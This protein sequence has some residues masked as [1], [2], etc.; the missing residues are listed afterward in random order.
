[1]LRTRARVVFLLIILILL[2]VS[3]LLGLVTWWLDQQ[4]PQDRGAGSELWTAGG[5]TA[6]ASSIIT[7]MERWTG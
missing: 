6:S 7:G 1:M 2:V 3:G 4:T 5:L